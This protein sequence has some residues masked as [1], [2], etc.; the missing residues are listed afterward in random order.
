M[1]DVEKL[2]KSKELAALLGT[3]EA[4]ISNARRRGQLPPA[5]RLPGVG[6]RWRLAD[7]ERWIA[8]HAEAAA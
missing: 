6:L 5:V 4:Q 7:V 2:L 1:R 3:T 8:E